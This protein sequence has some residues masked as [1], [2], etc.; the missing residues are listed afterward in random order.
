M[1]ISRNREDY[2]VTTPVTL[3]YSDQ[4]PMQHINNVAI[5]AILES[6]RVG[7]LHHIFEGVDFPDNR[8][9]LGRVSIDY[10]REVTYPGTVDVCGRLV[11]VGNR[12]FTSQY[13]LFQNGE[14]R[15]VSES[16]NVFFDPEKRISREPEPEIRAHLMA[17]V[18]G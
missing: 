4:D 11:R 5:A 17:Q 13:G 2:I 1:E 12:S 7:L 10:L 16:T 15:V 3:R 8:M 9:V 14:C 18:A 6:G